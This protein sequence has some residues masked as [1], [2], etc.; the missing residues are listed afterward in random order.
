[1]YA[2]E[3][4]FVYPYTPTTTGT[5]DMTLSWG[6][7][8]L[9]GLSPRSTAAIWGWMHEVAG[10]TDAGPEDGRQRPVLRPEDYCTN[11]DSF[12]FGSNPEWAHGY[13]SDAANHPVYFGVMPY[14]GDVSF[15]PRGRVHARRWRESTSSTRPVPPRQPTALLTCRPCRVERRATGTW[16]SSRQ[17][18]SVAPPERPTPTGTTMPRGASPWL[19]RARPG[20]LLM[21]VPGSRGPRR[22]QTTRRL[23]SDRTSCP[24]ADRPRTALPAPQARRRVGRRVVQR[25]PG[26]LAVVQDAERARDQS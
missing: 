18:W 16:H 9:R 23:T 12:Y 3:N 26:D 1:M 11:P 21:W 19:R 2:Q 17:Y 14:A 10:L 13:D 7:A 4:T 25:G 22:R 24:T 20:P 5:Y 6:T 15:T 8:R